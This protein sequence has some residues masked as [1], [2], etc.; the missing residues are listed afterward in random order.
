[1]HFLRAM[2][3]RSWSNPSKKHRKLIQARLGVHPRPLQARVTPSSGPKAPS[4]ILWKQAQN[5]RSG[6]IRELSSGSTAAE[7]PHSGSAA[8]PQRP[9]LRP[10]SRAYCR[11]RSRVATALHASLHPSLMHPT[12]AAHAKCTSTTTKSAHSRM[13]NTPLQVFSAVVH[14]KITPRRVQFALSRL[15]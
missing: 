11:V 2:T 12:L 6:R 7:R 10:C 4:S 1:M 5:S 13:R 14:P 9:H 3:R 15:S 8:A